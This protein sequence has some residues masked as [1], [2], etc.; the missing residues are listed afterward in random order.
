MFG[1]EHYQMLTTSGNLASSLKG[2]GKYAEAT[3]IEREVL[4]QKT[5]LLGAEHE[6]TLTTA[7]NLT[8][9]L[10]QCGQKREADQLL[11][12]ALALSRRALGRT[13]AH[14]EYASIY[15]FNWPRSAVSYQDFRDGQ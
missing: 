9:S 14:A 3:E 10:W 11:R 6:S 5:R 8:N 7:A 2:Q 1:R 13:H 15:A 12:E 4:I